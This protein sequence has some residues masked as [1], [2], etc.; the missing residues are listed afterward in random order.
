MDLAI[1]GLGKMGA[2]ISLRLL[3]GGHRVV[4][5]DVDALSIE[6][7]VKHGAEGARSLED[8]VSKLPPPAR[9]WVM[10][11]SGDAT[12]QTLDTLAGLMKPGD[13]LVDGGNTHYKQSVARGQALAAQ[14]VHFLDVGTS[15]GVWGLE[16]GYSLMIGGTDS[17]V[18]ALE[19]V[20]KTLAPA[21]DQGWGHV[22]PSGAGH[23]VKMVHNGIE[24]GAMQAFAEGFALLH[25]KNDL[26][27]D[28]SQVAQIWQHGSV[29][30][31]WLLDLAAAALKDD[32]GLEKIA[33]HV[34]DSGEGRWMVAE[35]IEQDVAAPV[36]T[37]ALLQR[38]RSRETLGFSDRL[39]AALRQQFGGHA[40]KPP[41]ME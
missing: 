26:T 16:N 10:V 20:F 29:V 11:P 18:G 21:P 9:V 2:S 8:V 30:R 27:V 6:P 24:Y 40:V 22:G 3:R 7:L 19:P 1:V 17:A 12:Q 39:L 35:A 33:P 28:L 23:F 37:L 15:G 14:G 5:Y 31:S 36:I 13:I 4:V 25:K 38:I 41:D 32:P 34:A